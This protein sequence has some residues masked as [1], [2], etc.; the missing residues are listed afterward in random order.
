MS[1]PYASSFRVRVCVGLLLLHFLYF[2]VFNFQAY[3]ALALKLH[4]D[5]NR[6]DP[7]VR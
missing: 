1:L 4:P 5:R 2:V 7:N 6:D 3:V